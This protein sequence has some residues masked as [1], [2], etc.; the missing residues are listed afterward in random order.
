MVSIDML[1]SAKVIAVVHG[2]TIL[3]NIHE[4]GVGV[5]MDTC[6]TRRP[7][8]K[9]PPFFRPARFICPCFTSCLDSRY[10]DAPIS[11]RS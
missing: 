10:H 11:S 1:D 9:S 4:F 2:K 5:Q 7:V 8:A 3:E 6:E